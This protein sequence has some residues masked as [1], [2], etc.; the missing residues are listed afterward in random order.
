MNI[1]AKQ[2]YNHVSEIYSLIFAL[3]VYPFIGIQNRYQ[4]IVLICP[5]NVCLWDKIEIA[6]KRVYDIF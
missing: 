6:I 3:A 1:V 4:N 2:V 5:S